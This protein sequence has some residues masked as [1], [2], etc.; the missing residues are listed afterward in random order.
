MTTPP[1]RLASGGEIDRARSLGFVFDGT[2]HVGHPGDTLASALLANG[3]RLVGRSFKYHRPRGIVAA[4]PEEPNALMGVGLGARA[5]PDTRATMQELFDGLVAASQNRFPSLALDFGAIAQLAAPLIP[6][7]FY[8]KTFKGTPGWMFWEALIRRAAGLGRATTEPDPDRY[9]RRHASCDVLVVG[10][11]PA[12][13]AAARAAAA[14]GARVIVCDERPGFGGS[15]RFEREPVDGR[16]PRDWAD[17]VAAELAANPRVTSLARTTAFGIYD[18][19]QVALIERVSDHRPPA[20]DGL[21]RQRRWRGSPSAA[22]GR[23]S[24][25]RSM[26][27]TCP[28]S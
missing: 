24:P 16:R 26:S 4:G 7:G 5:E 10:A 9:E 12:G 18:H 27:A 1:F 6:A 2:R 22:G 25:T 8:Y 15:L 3:V 14:S 13:L 19:G 11:G 17:A 21:P 28:W 20:V 23:W